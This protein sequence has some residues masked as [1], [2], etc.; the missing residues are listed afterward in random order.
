MS[1]TGSP[2]PPQPSFAAAFHREGEAPTADA[3]SQHAGP[4]V[5]D[6]VVVT[7]SVPSPRSLL[8]CL[9]LGLLTMAGA[10]PT[11]VDHGLLRGPAAMNGSARGTALVMFVLALPVLAIG[12]R[13]TRKGAAWGWPLIL[14][15]VA[16]L[17][18]NAVMLVFGTPFNHAFLVYVAILSLSVWTTVSLL[19]DLDV[20]AFATR[21]RPTLPVRPIAI[22]TWV[23]VGLNAL[24][25]L[26]G[27]VPAS[28]EDG[29]PQLL[30]GTGLTTIPTYIQDLAWWL[31]LMGLAAW[32]LWRRAA[33]GYVLISAGLVM[34]VLESV[35]VAVDQYWGH[36]ADPS[37][38]VIAPAMV[39]VFAVLAVVGTVPVVVIVRRL[40]RHH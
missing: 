1:T 29:T 31:P 9:A 8:L 10:I 36:L 38:P 25:W 32:W 28:L 21:L 7:G 23:I 3:Q 22:Y 6:A 13:A 24:I 27:A 35:G 17:L 26:K 5:V 37:S 14:G 16:Y 39:P 34:W 20:E 33:W 12:W 18:Y 19:G 2:V 11:I 30:E 15:A 4:S 40:A